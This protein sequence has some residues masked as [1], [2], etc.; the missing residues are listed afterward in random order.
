MLEAKEVTLENVLRLPGDEAEKG[1][2]KNRQE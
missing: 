2:H 1:A